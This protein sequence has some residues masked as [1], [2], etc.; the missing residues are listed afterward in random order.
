[1]GNYTFI[2]SPNNY[3]IFKN[4]FVLLL[5]NKTNFVHSHGFTAAILIA[6]LQRIFRTPHLM[7]AHDVLLDRQFIGIK[8]RLKKLVLGGA[9]KRI[10]AI[11]AVSEDGA[12]NLLTFFPL[13]NRSKIHTILHGIDV[14]SFYNAQP[15]RQVV[16]TVVEDTVLIGFFGRFMSQKGFRYLVDAIQIITKEELIKRPVKVLAF[17]GGGFVR[18]EFDVI[19]S[20]GLDDYFELMPF[21]EDMPGAIKAVDIVAMPSLWEACGLLA[22]EALVAGTPIIGTSC[23]GL[24][25]VLEGSPSLV[26]PPADSKALALAIAREINEPR[27]GEFRD[28]ASV[29]K[30]RF[31]LEKP[32]DELDKLYKM[33]S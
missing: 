4:S 13:L 28:Y 8:G 6:F 1:M 7:T 2:P 16:D 26:V 18:E 5:N 17:G 27:I 25:E 11:H 14:D 20:R 23:I 22:M 24:R 19:K 33:L 15:S 30:V 32:V 10:D 21:T 29:A 31:S 12:K 3:Y 9:F